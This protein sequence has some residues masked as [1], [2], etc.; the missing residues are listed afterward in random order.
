MEIPKCAALVVVL[1]G[2]E[3]IVILRESIM[4]FSA[5]AE[6]SAV[7]LADLSSPPRESLREALPSGKP[8]KVLLMPGYAKDLALEELRKDALK[9][10]FSFGLLAFSNEMLKQSLDSQAVESLPVGWQDVDVYQTVSNVRYRRNVDVFIRLSLF[11]ILGPVEPC[12]FPISYSTSRMVAAAWTNVCVDANCY[13]VTQAMGLRMYLQTKE[14]LQGQRLARDMLEHQLILAA[15][16]AQLYTEAYDLLQ[17][18]ISYASDGWADT[19]GL[20]WAMCLRNECA[21]AMQHPLEK[22]FSNLCDCA[23]LGISIARMEG[24]L[25]LN[26]IM[27]RNNRQH[28]TVFGLAALAN[29]P[30]NGA[31]WM[32]DASSSTCRLRDNLGVS[33]YHIGDSAKS[34]GAEQMFCASRH[35]VARLNAKIQGNYNCVAVA[36]DAMPIVSLFPSPADLL[37]PDFVVH[38]SLFPPEKAEAVFSIS[39]ASSRLDWNWLKIIFCNAV[40]SVYAMEWGGSVTAGSQSLPT[41]H[42]AILCQAATHPWLFNGVSD[43]VGTKGYVFVLGVRGTE[44]TTLNGNGF[45]AVLT[46]GTLVCIRAGKPWQLSVSDPGVDIQT[47]LVSCLAFSHFT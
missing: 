18:R 46:P 10:G 23:A 43:C 47:V 12:P 26:A 38:T 31:A 20:Y 30:M 44:R 14:R 39:E 35:P 40:R 15:M 27:T 5:P 6:V 21:E 34:A 37:L 8:V 16:Q 1:D 45:S 3:G 13:Q 24:Y 9:D 11:N 36:S 28:L 29:A 42:G 7:Y 25:H 19:D 4:S 22:N 33:L 2:D 41:E 17:K 32:G